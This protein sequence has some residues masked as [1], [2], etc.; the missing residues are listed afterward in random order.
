VSARQ[1]G[2]L[3]SAGALLTILIL[4]SAP[5][6]LRR[7]GALTL[8]VI[9]LTLE[10]TLVGLLAFTNITP[11][12]LLFFVLYRGVVA[13]LIFVFDLFL[14]SASPKES[15]TGKIRGLYWALSNTALIISPTIAG[16]LAGDG[17]FQ[18]V[19]IFSSLF[20]IPVIIIV[21]HNLRGEAKNIRAPKGMLQA[22]PVFLKHRDLRNILCARFLLRL[23][24]AWM[25]IYIPVY[26]SQVLGFNWKEIGFML[27]FMLLPFALFQ[28]PAGYLADKKLGEKEL[29]VLGFIL[30]ATFTLIFA[31]IGQPIFILLAIIL[32][33]TRVGAS[34]IEIMTESYFFKHVNE[35]DG[36]V[37]SIF[38]A[39]SPF[40]YVIGPLLGALALSFVSFEAMFGILGFV[41]YLGIFFAL[42]IR[43]TK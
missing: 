39:T 7:F 1:V 29:L 22:I 35:D 40:A 41:M 43:D 2:L 24:Y 13:S 37:I 10:F 21:I 36:N 38:R 27:T 28:F 31:L 20:V 19:Y 33:M 17:N 8:T 11:L 23:F 9:L 25:V 15:D 30:I 14:E 26:L 18:R 16:L 6:L 42:Q 3:F 32:F 4:F 12:V 34:L 5:T